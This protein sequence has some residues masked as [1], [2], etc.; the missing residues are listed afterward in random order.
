VALNNEKEY[1]DYLINPPI[2]YICRNLA[3]HLDC[4]DY[5]VV[6]DYLYHEGLMAR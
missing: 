2:N 6:D 1:I 5:D 3:K 4:I